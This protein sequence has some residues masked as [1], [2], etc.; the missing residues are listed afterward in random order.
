M[1]TM[2]RKEIRALKRAASGQGNA[3]AM[4]MLLQRSVRFGHRKLALIRCIQAERM[5]IRIAPEVLTYCR[6]IADRMTPER[7]DAIVRKATES[8]KGAA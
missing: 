6:D 8:P 3:D 2:K 1:T 4:Q 5:G 7:L